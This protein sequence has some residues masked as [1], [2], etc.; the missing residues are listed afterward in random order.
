M[1][2]YTLDEATGFVTRVSDG[3]VVAP[4]QTETDPDFIEY[5]TWCGLGNEPDVTRSVIVQVPKSVT[6]RQMKLVLFNTPFGNSTLY[7]LI[8]Y[9]FKNHPNGRMLQVVWDSAGEFER[10]DATLNTFYPQL[11]LSPSMVDQLFI[12]A[13]AIV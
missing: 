3:K 1:K 9:F 10:D 13:G 11:G 12:A 5:L 2:D 7:D 4:A 8:E 6:A